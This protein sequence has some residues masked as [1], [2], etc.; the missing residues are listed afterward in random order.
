M[1]LEMAAVF[2]VISVSIVAIALALR[3]LERDVF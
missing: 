1:S 2:A 3:E